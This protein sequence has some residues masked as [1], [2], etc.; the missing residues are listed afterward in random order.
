MIGY[1]PKERI[2]LYSGICL[3]ALIGLCADLE[4]SKVIHQQYLGW[5]LLP[6]AILTGGLVGGVLGTIPSIRRNKRQL[7]ELEKRINKNDRFRE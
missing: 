6:E 3:G 1:T 5:F 4:I 2:Y 7:S